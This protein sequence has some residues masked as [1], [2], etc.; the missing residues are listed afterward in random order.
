M[1]KIT[2]ELQAERQGRTRRTGS[3]PTGPGVLCPLGCAGFPAVIGS[4]YD[5]AAV[6][7]EP[8]EESG[9]GDRHPAQVY[10]VIGGIAEQSSRP[11][12]GTGAFLSLAGFAV[13][14]QKWR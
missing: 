4:A 1:P 13:S 11:H 7:P 9:V 10:A 8:G 12:Y 5:V 3:F 14:P 6:K 2:P